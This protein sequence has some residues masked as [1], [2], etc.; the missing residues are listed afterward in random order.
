MMFRKFPFKLLIKQNPPANIEINMYINYLEN[1]E[2][3]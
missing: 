3:L 2:A 1:C